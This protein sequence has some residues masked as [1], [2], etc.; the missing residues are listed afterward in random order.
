MESSF[1][2]KALQ[3]ALDK[4]GKPAI[5][6]TDQGVQFTSEAFVDTLLREDILVSM[7]GKG[8]ATDNIFI[9]RLWRSVKYEDVYLKSYSD[10]QSLF[11]GLES[12]F[13]FYNTQR[14]HQNLAKLTP[15][16]VYFQLKEKDLLQKVPDI[17]RN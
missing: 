1:C 14:P 9:E 8:R 10:R 11:A 13:Q 7:D 17:N 6:N 3:I 15:A 4:F 12:Y 5:F 16:E 2:V